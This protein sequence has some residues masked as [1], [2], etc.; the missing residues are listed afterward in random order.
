MLLTSAGT[1]SNGNVEPEKARAKRVKLASEI[2]PASEYKKWR[3]LRGISVGEIRFTVARSKMDGIIAGWVPVLPAELF[4]R[5]D[6]SAP[7][8]DE[9]RTPCLP[10]VCDRCGYKQSRDYSA[11]QDFAV[12][13]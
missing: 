11:R 10:L 4:P 5:E 13:A 1:A 6:S 2:P 9:S 7:C 3:R 8:P 12:P